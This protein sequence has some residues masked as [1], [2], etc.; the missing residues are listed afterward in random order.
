MTPHELLQVAQEQ[1]VTLIRDGDALRYRGPAG[2]L[3][4]ALRIAITEQKVALLTVLDSANKNTALGS[5][6]RATLQHSG[7][8]S[9]EP[10]A[11]RGETD[12]GSVARG[13]AQTVA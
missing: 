11:P 2:A 5:E 4:G 13:A 8:T 1:G 3:D 6:S 9:V 10:Q 7:P 12:D